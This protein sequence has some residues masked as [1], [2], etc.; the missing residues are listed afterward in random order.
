MS[1]EQVRVLQGG[2]EHNED[3]QIGNVRI[4]EKDEIDIKD[5]FEIWSDDEALESRLILHVSFDVNDK[6]HI[7]GTNFH[8]YNS[9]LVLICY[10]IENV[11]RILT[12]VLFV[13]FDL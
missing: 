7:E 10:N 2:A 9:S 6:V 4:C 3:T 5:S 1:H 12:R 13:N 11:L 8:D